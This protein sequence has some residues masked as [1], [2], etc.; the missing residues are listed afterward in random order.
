MGVQPAGPGSCK[1]E[2]IRAVRIGWEGR[3]CTPVPVSVC[4]YTSMYV[5]ICVCTQ[6]ICVYALV[7]GCAGVYMCAFAWVCTCVH[8]GYSCVHVHPRV[9][10]HVP[11]NHVCIGNADHRDDRDPALP[12]GPNVTIL[13]QPLAT[14]FP[15][16]FA[17]R[18]LRPG[19]G[20]GLQATG[21]L[22]LCLWLLTQ[23]MAFQPNSSHPA[24]H[25]RQAWMRI[26]V[27]TPQRAF[28][29]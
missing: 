3:A 10:M 11:C 1:E 2:L 4:V 26:S 16:E 20:G 24:I 28:R 12:W 8:M 21:V 9:H 19:Q 29:V 7:H 15:Q 18:W 13:A 17:A 25:Q 5:W 23:A 27:S 22:R 14:Q 6:H